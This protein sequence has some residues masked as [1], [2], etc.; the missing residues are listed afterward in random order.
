MKWIYES[1]PFPTWHWKSDGLYDL[2]LGGDTAVFRDPAQPQVW[3]AV[4]DGKEIARGGFWT[5]RRAV[6]AAS[7]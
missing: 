7:C 2:C 3:M 6:E 5:V 1:G 4:R